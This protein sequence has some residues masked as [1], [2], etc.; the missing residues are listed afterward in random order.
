MSTNRAE[1][2]PVAKDAGGTEGGFTP[3]TEAVWA[4]GETYVPRGFKGL[5]ANFYVTSCA[6]FSTLGGLLF[7]YE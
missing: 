1:G 3:H 2:G 4:A 7:G 5:F 6:A